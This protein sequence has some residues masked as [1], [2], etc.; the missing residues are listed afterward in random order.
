MIVGNRVPRDQ[1]LV[2][3]DKETLDFRDFLE[4]LDPKAQLDELEKRE[5]RVTVRMEA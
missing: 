3:V 5:K 2:P 4:S 1:A